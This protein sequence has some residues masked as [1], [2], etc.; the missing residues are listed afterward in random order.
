MTTWQFNPE[1]TFEQAGS[2]WIVLDASAGVV[3]RAS[4]PA[5]HALTAIAVIAT[6]I[7]EATG[8]AA[9]A[10]LLPAHLDDTVAALAERGVIVAKTNTNTHA[11]P[12]DI[13]GATTG[14][15]RRRLISTG[16]L[17]AGAATVATSAGIHTLI[18]PTAASAASPSATLA[19]PT[20]VTAIPSDSQ[21]VTVN[22]TIVGGATSYQVFY[23]I[24]GAGSYTEFVPPS[25]PIT[26]GPV[27]V[28]GL[29]NTTNYEFYVVAVNATTT[30]VPSNP[31]ANATATVRP[32]ERVGAVTLTAGERDLISAVTDGT[33]GYFGTDTAQPG[34]VVKVNLSSMTRPESPAAAAVTLNSG[35]NFLYT[36]VTAGGFGYFG[37]H[38]DP[39]RVVKVNLSTMGRVDA[40]TLNT[41]E[42]KPRSAVT[43]G[44]FGYFGTQT[45]PGRVVKVNLS[46]MTRVGA[47]TLETGENGLYSAVTD[48][49]FGY[50]GTS[51]SPGR[52]VKVRLSD[53]T[54][55]DAVTLSADEDFLESAVTDGTF[56]YFGTGTFPGRVV[57]VRLS[58]MTRVGAV[59]LSA[60]EDDLRSAVTD[61]TFGYFGTGTSFSPDGP[62]PSRVVKVR[63]SDMT[64]VGALTLETGENGL[65]SAVTDGTFGY[66]GTLTN[67][68][69]IVKVQ[70]NYAV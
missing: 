6:A 57:K 44:T 52:V 28:T 17:A 12:T 31:L 10:D 53:M 56:G 29:T 13:N 14:M 7:P 27:T 62:S 26:A 40:L 4:G 49:T 1:L 46:D 60:G 68:G 51:T 45:N 64:R 63:L 55:V 39:G 9:N 11:H 67:P 43:D 20:G 25:T 21:Q 23:R 69:R 58:D 59:T 65:Y 22:W 42:N 41:G 30:S 33:F 70:V 50:F 54:R 16:A 61:G 2:D 15:S 47:L 8:I 66:F 38:T 48:G 37:T 36:A 18:L 3:L 35:E 19:A 24:F 34:R 32:F 5:A